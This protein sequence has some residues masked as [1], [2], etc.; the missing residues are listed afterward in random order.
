M[1]NRFAWSCIVAIVFAT[2]SSLS[3]RAW[4]EYR[5]VC[6]LFRCAAETGTLYLDCTETWI[7]QIRI[8]GPGQLTAAVVASKLRQGNYNERVIA[9]DV[10]LELPQI[11]R[12][13]VPGLIEAVSDRDVQLSVKAMQVLGTIRENSSAT[14]Q[15]L[16]DKL[17]S[18]SYLERVSSAAA[19]CQIDGEYRDNG[20]M[21]LIEI[22]G[23]D[24]VDVAYRSIAADRLGTLGRVA[25]RALPTL[26]NVLAH[27]L[28]DDL[29][30]KVRRAIIAIRASQ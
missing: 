23:D 8:I 4:R 3:V 9:A 29:C 16:V 24:E 21:V 27:T 20:L 1:F 6:E 10:I 17:D 26:E 12:P 13:A 28:D 22:I 7:D 14:I 25:F 30:D 18:D 19:L 2:L 5:P 15:A 11:A